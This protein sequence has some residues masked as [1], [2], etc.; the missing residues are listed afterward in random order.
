VKERR[1]TAKK[2]PE[3]LSGRRNTKMGEEGHKEKEIMKEQ[4]Q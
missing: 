3:N 1:S 4:D 2:K